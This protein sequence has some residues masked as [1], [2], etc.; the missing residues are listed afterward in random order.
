[1]KSTLWVMRLETDNKLYL[2][3]NEMVLKY[4]IEW[5]NRQHIHFLVSDYISVIASTRPIHYRD[6]EKIHNNYYENKY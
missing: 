6:N 2:S 3:R 4:C 5:S 1:M